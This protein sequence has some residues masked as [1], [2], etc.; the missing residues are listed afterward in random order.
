M[1]SSPEF[2]ALPVCDN[3]GCHR[4]MENQRKNRTRRGRHALVSVSVFGLLAVA[5]CLSQAPSAFGQIQSTI[6]CPAGHGYWDILSVMM[7]D[8]GLASNNHMEGI[9]NGL[10]SSYVYTMWDPSQTKLYYVKNP[11]GNPWDINLYDANYIYQ[12]VTELDV[13]NGVN[14]WNDPTS[15]RKLNNGSQST[16]SDFSMRW[17]ARCAAPGGAESSFWNPPPPA[18]ASNTNYLTY[19]GQVL[20]SQAQNLGYARLKLQKTDTM[21]ITDNRA[22]PPQSFSITTLPLQYT[23]SCSVSEQLNSC[24]FREVFDYGVDTG[25]N[26][27]DNVKHSYGWVRWRYYTNLTLGDPDLPAIWVLSNTSTSDQLMPGQVNVNFQCF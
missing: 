14:Y 1:Q 5:I 9:T 3:A 8:P 2:F 18:Q 17:A 22:N 10:P 25:V 23:Y 27:V 21:T 15:C 16:T 26:P 12:W 13:W 19:V 7:M 11:Q 4:E 6:S 24:Q 20:Q